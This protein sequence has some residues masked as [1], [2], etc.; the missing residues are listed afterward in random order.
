[1]P[2]DKEQDDKKT[3]IKSGGKREQDEAEILA[4]FDDEFNK[5]IAGRSEHEQDWNVCDW[6]IEANT[7]YDAYGRL[8]VNPPL[9]QSLRELATGRMSG[10]MNYTLEP[11]GKK[12]IAEDSIVAKYTLAHYIQA[13]KMHK[14]IMKARTECATY[15]TAVYYTGVIAQTTM[16]YRIKEDTEVESKNILRSTDYDE[17][18][19]YTYEF[20]GK[21]VPL[22]D[23]WLDENSLE[24]NNI[25]EADKCVMKETMSVE[26]F[27]T[28]FDEDVFKGVE[29]IDEWYMD[30]NPSYWE[31]KQSPEKEV[32]IYYYFNQVTKDMWIIANRTKVIF[33]GKMT[34]KSGWLPFSSKQH[35]TNHKCFYWYGICHKVRY[36]KAYK[37]E[38]LQDILDQS[39]MWGFWVIAGNDNKTDE[40]WIHEPGKINVMRFSWDTQNVRTYDFNPDLN[41]YYNILALLDDLVIQDTWENL[42]GTYTAVAEQLWTVEIIEN[43]RMTR[44]ATVD[45]NDDHFL[46]DILTQILDNITQYASKMQSKTTVNEDWVEETEYPIIQIKDA[47]V[48]KT[49]DG[50]TTIIKDHGEDWYFEFREDIIEWR[51]L[52]K[53]VTN[54][55]INTQKTLEK[56]SITQYVNNFAMLANLNPELLQVED[57]KWILDLMKTLYWYD[58]EFMI[59]TTRDKNKRINLE[60]M[61]AIQ[62]SIGLINNDNM[63]NETTPTNQSV[64]PNQAPA[65]PENQEIV[66]WQSTA[67]NQMPDS[68]GTG[69]WTLI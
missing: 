27:K 34:N 54:S 69:G 28:Q 59:D 41:K 43:S 19:E 18:K 56:N 45:E 62:E 25:Q 16:N 21:N 1:M 24:N 9:E 8:Q 49:D 42:K 47:S 67:G 64:L 10:K 12:P 68:R 55:N 35:Y 61:Q 60:I 6:Q 11:I 58:D 37:A 14:K 53:V 2:Y 51:Y 3:V 29:D 31:S 40:S 46:C 39:K 17:I 26:K 38:M 44:L 50:R 52:V 20:T 57:V 36:L 66:P 15:W 23:F 4:R 65:I 22:R 63:Q 48:K 32:L 5:M 30:A 33:A 13:E 7:Y